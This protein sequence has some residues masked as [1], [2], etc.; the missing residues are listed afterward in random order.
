V[1][2][3]APLG[4]RPCGRQVGTGAGLREA[5]APDLLR[6]EDLREVRLL[7]LVGSVRHDRRTRHPEPD[8]AYVRGG[9]RP[10][11]LLVEDRLEAVR[12]AGAAVFGGP[13]QTGVARVVELAAPL[14]AER[15]VE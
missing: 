10:R 15:V 3:V 11:H 14:A 12:R 7:L 1:H 5:L 13:G 2:V 6:G 4:P 8:H 9:L